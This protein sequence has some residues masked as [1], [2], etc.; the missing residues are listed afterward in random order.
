MGSNEGDQLVSNSPERK[1]FSF[2]MDQEMGVGGG[3]L[4]LG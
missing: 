3:G 2:S 4:N 1:D